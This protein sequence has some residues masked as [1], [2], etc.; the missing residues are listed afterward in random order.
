MRKSAAG[1]QPS[2]LSLQTS[3]LILGADGGF[4][5]TTTFYSERMVYILTTT[6][7]Y[8]TIIPAEVM[9]NY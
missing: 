5:T 8:S 9:K 3:F 2:S 4:K 1:G 6:I 7:L